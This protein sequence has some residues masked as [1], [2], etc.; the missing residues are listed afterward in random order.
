MFKVNK[1]N[2]VVVILLLTL[3]KFI[4]G[5]SVSIVN[6]AS[7]VLVMDK[8]KKFYLLDPLSYPL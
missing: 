6:F 8:R 3:N 2:D 7:P 5:S 1:V 4:P